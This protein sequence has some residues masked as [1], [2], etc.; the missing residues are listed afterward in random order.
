[1]AAPWLTQSDID[2]INSVQSEWVAKLSPRFEGKTE[3]EIRGMFGV[4]VP[5]DRLD[6][7]KA[8]YSALREFVTVDPAF[9]SRTKWPQCKGAI[10][11]QGQCGSCWAFGAVEAF[12]DRICI[13]RKSASVTFSSPQALVDCD[14]QE[15]GCGGGWPE[16]AWGYLRD[17]GIPSEKCYPYK[18][19]DQNCNKKCADGSAWTVTK[20]TSVHTYSSTDDA[21]TD[22]QAVG[23]IETWFA[24]YQDFLNYHSGIYTPTSPTLLGYHA[25]EIIGWGVEGGVNF[26]TAANSW[27]GSW[28]DKGYFK[29]KAGTCQFDQPDHLVSGNVA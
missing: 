19:Y 15:Y 22:I 21:K 20:A 16:K 25:V 8:D 13:A 10:R 14:T 29:I 11:D 4:R 17:N 9:D 12:D 18:A 5:E 6:L 3:E 1:M 26:W 24:V 7:P 2:H 28:G 23:P 27:G